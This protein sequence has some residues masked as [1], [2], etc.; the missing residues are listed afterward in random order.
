MRVEECETKG[1]GESVY[2]RKCMD[3]EFTKEGVGECPTTSMREG[4]V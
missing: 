4:K 1:I 3:K 2:M